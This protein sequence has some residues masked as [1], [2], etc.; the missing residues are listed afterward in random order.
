MD[1]DSRGFGFLEPFTTR[2]HGNIRLKESSAAHPCIFLFTEKG[3]GTTE[4]PDLHLTYKD[5]KQLHA[6]LGEM[7]AYTKERWEEL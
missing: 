1:K 2:Y 7:I 3:Y 4:A 5:A 6:K